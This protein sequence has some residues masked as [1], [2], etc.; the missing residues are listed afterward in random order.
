MK[1]K[2]RENIFRTI[3]TGNFPKLTITIKPHIL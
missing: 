3:M 1:K 2:G